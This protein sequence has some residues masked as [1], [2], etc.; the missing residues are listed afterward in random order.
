VTA[1]SRDGCAPASV[2][3]KATCRSV[4]T[5][6]MPIGGRG[7]E[8]RITDPFPLSGDVLTCGDATLANGLLMT[9][10]SDLEVSRR[11]SRVSHNGLQGRLCAQ[12]WG[13]RPDTRWDHRSHL[14]RS[15]AVSTSSVCDPTT[16]YVR[17]GRRVSVLSA[18][19]VVGCRLP[20]PTSPPVAHQAPTAAPGGTKRPWPLSR[21]LRE[22]L[23]PLRKPLDLPPGLIRWSAGFPHRPCRPSELP[24]QIGRVFFGPKGLPS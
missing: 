5:A 16:D 22:P 6:W 4:L 10:P 12:S 21:P 19:P 15:R 3:L 1:E 2:D 13:V 11:V 23:G 9:R 7:I 24:L 14:N 18:Q 17:H 20:S 8:Q